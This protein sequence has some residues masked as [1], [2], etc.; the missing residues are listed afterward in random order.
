MYRAGTP[1]IEG[2]WKYADK[3]VTIDLAQTQEGDA[4]RLPMEVAVGGKV[5]RIEMT[6]KKQRFELA[7][8]EAPADVTLDPN[9]W[10]L[11]EAKFAKQ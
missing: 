1:K 11:M 10:I 2:T 6:E 4:Y 3:K 9:T 8:G 5:E 7:A